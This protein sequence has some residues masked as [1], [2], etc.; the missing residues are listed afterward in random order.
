MSRSKKTH[1]G[2]SSTRSRKVETG[3]DSKITNWTT[4][5]NETN[6]IVEITDKPTE[7]QEEKNDAM[8]SSCEIFSPSISS[9]SQD[10]IDIYVDCDSNNSDDFSILPDS[11]PID[12]LANNKLKA[13]E[14]LP[15]ANELD[16]SFQNSNFEQINK[17]IDSKQNNNRFSQQCSFVILKDKN[18]SNNTVIPVEIKRKIIPVLK[19]TKNIFN[20]TMQGIKVLLQSIFTKNHIKKINSVYLSYYSK[21]MQKNPNTVLKNKKKCSEYVKTDNFLLYDVLSKKIFLI[22]SMSFT[23]FIAS[24][25][26]LSKL[27]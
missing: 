15:M 4:E 12:S 19:K 23:I 21:I 18:Y 11:I 7:Q 8:N 13:I 14:K 26:I 10:K 6:K 27:K 1:S 3:K 20:V 5:I 9:D 22:F 17:Q 16:V 2:K 25:F 24:L